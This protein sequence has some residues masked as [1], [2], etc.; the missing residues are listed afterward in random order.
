MPSS[1][2]DV[3]VG[4]VLAAG[5]SRRLGQPKQLLPYG[6][7]TLLGHT[8]DVARAS[9]L[10]QVVVVLGAASEAVRAQVE[11]AGITVTESPA[12]EEGCALSIGTGL[13]ALRDDWTTLVLLLGDQPGVT[14]EAVAALCAGRGDAPSAVCQ[15]DDG[16]GHPLAFAR[17]LAGELA[18][19]HGDR[20][21]WKLLDRYADVA[22]RVPVAGPVPR[23]VDTWDDYEAVLA[24]VER[25]R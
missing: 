15:Y 1:A 17:D 4:L 8:L 2:E 19:L 16:P 3:R 18:A 22:A 5:S 11:L 20:G 24:L 7:G 9:A 14:P 6:P 21:V 12:P 13:L 10:D 25:D 23:D